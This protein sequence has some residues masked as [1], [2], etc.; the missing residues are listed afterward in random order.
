MLVM[1]DRSTPQAYVH[2]FRSADVDLLARAE[3]SLQ[4]GRARR[5]LCREHFVVAVCDAAAGGPEG[6]Q[7]R[8]KGAWEEFLTEFFFFLMLPQS[9]NRSLRK[10]EAQS[11]TNAVLR[12]RH[13]SREHRVQRNIVTLA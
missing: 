3:C 5:I 9:P 8:V 6:G 13:Q 1:A 10:G 7:G 2:R 11:A 4:R 12:A